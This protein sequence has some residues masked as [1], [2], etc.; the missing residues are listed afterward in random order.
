MSD[1]PSRPLRAPH[2]RLF[3]AIFGRPRAA[4]LWLRGVLPPAIADRLS[5]RT[6][7]MAPTHAISAR[8][9]ERRSDLVFQVRSS[10]GEVFVVADV[11]HQSGFDPTLPVRFTEYASGAW[12]AHLDSGGS[13]TA[14][15]AFLA[16]VPIPN[17]GD[18]A[19]LGLPT[20]A[21]RCGANSS[22]TLGIPPRSR[23]P[24][25]A[26]GDGRRRSE[27]P[28]F[29]IRRDPRPPPRLRL[30]QALPPGPAPVERMLLDFEPLFCH[31]DGE[32]SAFGPASVRLAWALLGRRTAQAETFARL[33]ALAKRTL[34][35]EGRGAFEQI[36]HYVY[37]TDEDSRAHLDEVLAVIPDEEV[38]AMGMSYAEQLRQDGLQRG[39]QQG[40]ERGLQQGLERGLQQGLE[41]GLEQGLERGR[42]AMVAALLDG[43]EARFGP[44]A[45]DMKARVRLADLAQLQAWHG[46]LFTAPS[47]D[48]LIR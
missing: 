20:D 17:S 26:L 35:D 36:V 22:D 5:W 28:P 45:D 14:L 18:S 39:L 29:G 48:G 23:L 16:V 7:T 13:P 41:R 44:V 34:H 46:S 47:A 10:T 27:S 19:R 2:D 4:R 33:A 6:L 43:L 31:L 38:R 25:G 30:V 11:E 12:R 40:L 37:H 21:D 42:Q 3:Q 1:E 32:P 24:L 15:P 8:L 9:R